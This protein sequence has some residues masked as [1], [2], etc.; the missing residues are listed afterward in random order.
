MYSLEEIRENYKRFPNAKIEKIAKNESKGLRREVLKVLKDEIIRRE[1]N[2]NLISWVDT[3][4][5][6][7]KGLE[8]QN[9]I[10]KIQNQNC[11]KCSEKS[12]LYGFETHTVKAFLIGT[13]TSRDEQILCETCGKLHK[14]KTIAI[15]FCSGWWSGKGFLLTPFTIIKDSLNFLFIDK[16]SDRILNSFVDDLTGSFRRYGINDSVL[17]RLIKWKNKSDDN[18]S[19]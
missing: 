1:L 17:T 18:P 14:I 15:T 10:E 13:S 16:I 12:K 19:Y 8:R 7:F 4:T 6:S 11:P 5:K 2:L 9:L 3:E